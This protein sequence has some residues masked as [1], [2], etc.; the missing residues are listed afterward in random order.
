[1]AA[2]VG[3]TEGGADFTEA[4]AAGTAV[5]RGTVRTCLTEG[6]TAAAVVACTEA[7]AAASTAAVIDRSRARG[8]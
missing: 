2:A 7:A 6:S 8:Q 5:V 4:E 1:M 3:S